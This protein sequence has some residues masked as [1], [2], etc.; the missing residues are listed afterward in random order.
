M[1][2]KL[3]L[4]IFLNCGDLFAQDFITSQ[5][6]NVRLLQNP[7]FA[8]YDEGTS[9]IGLLHRAQFITPG[10]FNTNSFTVDKRFCKPK[11]KIFGIGLG[12][13]ANREEQ[14]D[15][16]LKTINVGVIL[17]IHK[18]LSKSN[19]LSVGFQFGSIQQSIDW[20][21]LIFSDQIN[22]QGVES[23]ISSASNSNPN[24]GFVGFDL[25]GGILYKYKN[26][27]GTG[28]FIL[29]FSLFHFSQ[30][31]IGLINDQILP[32][33]TNFHIGKIWEK[34]SISHLSNFSIT[35]RWIQQNNFN[36]QSTDINLNITYNNLLISGIGI[37][38]NANKNLPQ[39]M[40]FILLNVGLSKVFFDNS[41]WQ[42]LVNYDLNVS[43]IVGPIGIIELSIVGNL[44]NK[45][46][47][48][49]KIICPTSF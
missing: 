17:G 35:G 16:F 31:N 49:R 24:V 27:T 39:N 4:L 36:Y 13:L 41:Y 11:P 45:C 3:I 2:L 44:N 8:G 22:F 47:K 28:P 5:I 12:M 15:G 48:N 37:R 29:G 34:T 6:Y 32:I 14:G 1:K 25:S 33:R 21:K 46:S 20:S 9:R 40:L 42:F 30:P 38:N 23:K 7:A 18:S 19:H 26:T 43:G 10:T